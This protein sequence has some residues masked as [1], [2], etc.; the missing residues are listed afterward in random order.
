[1]DRVRRGVGSGG[2]DLASEGGGLAFFRFDSRAGP[3]RS[4]LLQGLH[5]RSIVG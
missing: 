4:S 5:V 3:L 1:M 2:L